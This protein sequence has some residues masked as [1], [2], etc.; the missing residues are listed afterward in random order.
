MMLMIQLGVADLVWRW[1]WQERGVLHPA[2]GCV[3]AVVSRARRLDARS[4]PHG[5]QTAPASPVPG[6]TRSQQ[7]RDNAHGQVQACKLKRLEPRPRRGERSN[8]TGD[9]C[10]HSRADLNGYEARRELQ[11]AAGWLRFRR[12]RG[13]GAVQ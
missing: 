9:R 5:L 8:V 3:P 4:A 7:P 6:P 1:R 12:A 10:R 11:L 13:R 2:A